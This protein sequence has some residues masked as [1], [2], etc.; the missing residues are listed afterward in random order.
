MLASIVLI[1]VLIVIIVWATLCRNY[2]TL[3]MILYIL[4]KGL[5]A[6]HSSPY[7][8]EY[9]EENCKIWHSRDLMAKWIPVCC[10]FSLYIYLWYIYD[11]SDVLIPDLFKIIGW[12][13]IGVLLILNI[14]LVYKVYACD[15]K[16]YF[17][18]Q[19][20]KSKF[21]DYQKEMNRIIYDSL[22]R[23]FAP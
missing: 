6:Y 5:P 10:L 8:S 11:V 17:N 3:G 16:K 12:L 13:L 15:Y 18:E 2:Q 4:D 19:D 7:L 9:M 23:I 22:H 14:I 20:I 21:E 1:Y